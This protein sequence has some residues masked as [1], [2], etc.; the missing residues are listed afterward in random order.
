MKITK[1]VFIIGFIID[2][3]FILALLTLTLI[4]KWSWIPFWVLF[5][6]SFLI[7]AIT[8]I[9]IIVSYWQRKKPKLEQEDIGSALERIIHDMKHDRENPDNFLYVRHETIKVGE[10]GTT[11]TVIGIFYGKRSEDERKCAVIINLEKPDKETSI[12]Y[13]NGD[14][15]HLSEKDKKEIITAS[16]KI[17]DFPP[18][19]IETTTEY[20][21]D[22][23]GRPV[24]ITKVRKP[25]QRELKEREEKAEQEEK[26]GS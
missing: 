3:V 1:K 2:V 24:P 19:V 8:T 17:A 12:I 15:H 5:G 7:G 21:Y 22:E 25:S 10:Q 13:L 14:I 26:T 6:L 16:T 11:P 18:G 9:V 20:S 4:L 23:Q